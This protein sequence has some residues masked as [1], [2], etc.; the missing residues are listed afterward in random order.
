MPS[1]SHS[2]ARL[3]RRVL[4][5]ATAIAVAAAGIVTVA[6][7]AT[8]SGP[9][10]YGVPAASSTGFRLPF[11]G[12]RQY[13]GLAPSR[14]TATEQ[15]NAPLGADRAAAIA[16]ALG[17]N[18][19]DAFTA[20]Q[21]RLFSLGLGHKGDPAKS[22][23]AIASADILTNTTGRPLTSVVDG[24]E[25]RTVLGS[26]GL[27]VDKAGRLMSPANLAAPTRQINKLLTPDGYINQWMLANGAQQSLRMLYRSP[28]L[29]EAGFGYLAQQQS[30]AAQLVTATQRGATSTVG[31]SMAP[32]LW[33]V[34]FA[35]IWTLNPDL[36]AA[37]PATW[38]PIPTEVVTAIRQ[39][40]QGIVPWSDVRQY[41]PTS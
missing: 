14:A 10:G 4:T 27:F 18:R 34:N 21:F 41:F 28:Y 36:A 35:L 3:R 20:E 39:S 22:R 26:Y 11:S 15:I 9:G 30:G 23:L 2:A 31:M 5:V 32:A 24:Q 40:P 6:P 37:M 38:T 25:V 19:Q 17:L 1:S 16:A 12:L 8:A 33:L 29:A 7:T 13:E